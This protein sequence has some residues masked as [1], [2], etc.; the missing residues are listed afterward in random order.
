MLTYILVIFIINNKNNNF[1]M[2]GG[3][4]ILINPE[5]ILVDQ[6]AWGLR[7]KSNNQALSKGNKRSD[8]SG[9]QLLGHKAHALQL[10]SLEQQ[11]QSPAPTWP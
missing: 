9:R 7:K 4:G 10:F 1:G 8:N 6:Y 11:A 5:G 2:G 3:G